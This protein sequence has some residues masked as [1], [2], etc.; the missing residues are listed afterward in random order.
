MKEYLDYHSLQQL[1]NEWHCGITDVKYGIQN[2]L[3][4]AVMYIPYD[5]CYRVGARNFYALLTLALDG[6]EWTGSRPGRFISRERAPGMVS[7]PISLKRN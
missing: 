4:N 6:N 1:P 3:R 2:T 5:S 7:K